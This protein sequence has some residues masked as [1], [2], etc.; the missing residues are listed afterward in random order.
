MSVEARL[1]ALEA[2]A[3]GLEARLAALETG[4]PGAST[5]APSA[6]SPQHRTTRAAPAP[7][8]VADEKLMAQPWADMEIRKDP[9]RWAGESYVG[10]R[11][12]ECPKDYLENLAGFC[13]W[14]AKKGREESPPRLNNKGKPWYEADELMAKLARGFALRA[15]SA[16]PPIVHAP[17]PAFDEPEDDVPF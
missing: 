13:D 17:P 11:L 5:S 2:R 8:E 12:S 6:P 15:G 3:A 14:K 1:A 16:A 4:R 10:R 7:G 9:P